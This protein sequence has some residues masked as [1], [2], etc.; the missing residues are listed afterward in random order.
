MNPLS[1]Y[2]QAL[3]VVSNA[4][5]QG[6]FKRYS[7]QI[8][9]PYLVHTNLARL[10]IHAVEE[11]RPTFDALCQ[12]LQA[13]KVTHYER[14]ARAADYVGADR[15]DGWHFTHLISNG[16]HAAAPHSARLVLV[17]RT[18]GWRFSE[19]HYATEAASWPIPGHLLFPSSPLRGS[20]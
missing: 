20:A 6:D 10:L 4:V 13:H 5:L 2:Q 18:V 11:L 16:A 3:D 9:L 19:A 15:I 7:D 12:R 1:I 8:D 14:V 17:R